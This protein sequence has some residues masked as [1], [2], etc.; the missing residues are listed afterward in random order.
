M[1]EDEY[2]YVILAFD[3]QDLIFHIGTV[4]PLTVSDL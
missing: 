3:N 1:N 4:I 2:N